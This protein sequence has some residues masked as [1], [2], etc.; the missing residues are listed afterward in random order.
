MPRALPELRLDDLIAALGAAAPRFDVDIVDECTSTNAE[1]MRR[2]E[3]GA[4]SGSVLVA[5]RQTAGRGRM[6]RAWFSAPGASLTFSL[7]WRFAPGT[8]PYGLSLAVGVALA[9]AL[10][11]LGDEGLRLKWP[12]DLLRDGRKLAGVLIELVPGAPHAAVIGVGLNLSL[13]ADMPAELCA[14]AAALDRPIAPAQLLARL[15]AALQGVLDEFATGGFVAL[16]ARWLAR[17]GHID[18]PVSVLAEFAPPLN[19]RCV[20]VDVDGALMIETAVCV[21]R[22][23]SGE[24]SLRPAP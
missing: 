24:V 6:G 4:P 9:E 5:R 17:C 16:R 3:A 18:A 2:A 15:L 1:L 19:G 14:A 13:P 12:N 21:Q 23:L 22:V 20:G 11:A 10:E 7:L 8:Q